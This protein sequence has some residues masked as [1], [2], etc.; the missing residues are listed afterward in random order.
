MERTNL[1]TLTIQQAKERLFNGMWKDQSTYTITKDKK[2]VITPEERFY[3]KVIMPAKTWT[4]NGPYPNYGI[5]VALCEFDGTELVVSEETIK[6]KITKGDH[7]RLVS[8][9]ADANKIIWVKGSNYT[10]KHTG[11]MMYGKSWNIMK[12]TPKPRTMEEEMFQEV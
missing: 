8:I 7:D 12:D 4:N 6:L 9:N 10:N 5:T 1:K 3:M 2:S 11:Y